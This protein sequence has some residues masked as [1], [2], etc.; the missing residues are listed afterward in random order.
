MK[1][2]KYNIGDILKIKF[3]KEIKYAVIINEK[4]IDSMG[5]LLYE[6]IIQGIEAKTYWDSEYNLE[7]RIKEATYERKK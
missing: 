1:K 7:L 3:H 6:Y 5:S 4:L 2:Y